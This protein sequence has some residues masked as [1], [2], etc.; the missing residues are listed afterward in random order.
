[1]F[2]TPSGAVLPEAVALPG[3][4]EFGETAE[5]FENELTHLTINKDTC[6]PKCGGDSMDYDLA[7]SA[8]AE[9]ER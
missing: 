1:V 3:L 7:L 9:F 5:T 8:L 2:S 6:L 4:S